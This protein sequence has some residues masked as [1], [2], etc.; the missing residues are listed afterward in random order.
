MN[1]LANDGLH[2]LAIN[3]LEELGHTVFT[4]HVEQKD[5]AVWINENDVEAL[6]VRSATKVRE[7]LI[8]NCPN[9]KWI[10]RAGVGLDNIDVDYAT[11]Q[12]RHVFNTPKASSRSVAELVM[13][14]IYDW[15][16]RVGPANYMMGNA[17][18][19]DVKK[20]IS[21]ISYEVQG[22]TLGVIGFG[23]IGQTVATLAEANGMEILVY[24]PNVD[25]KWST[26]METLL[27]ESDFITVHISGKAE[28]LK[29][30]D[31]EMTKPNAVVINTARGGCINEE[32]L[33]NAIK[34]RRIA[35][36][37]LD[38]FMNEPEPD[39]R[40]LNNSRVIATPHIAGSTREAQAKIGLELVD[41][42]IALS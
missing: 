20:G 2:E 17:A 36:A 21:R 30:V 33:L 4:Q 14:Y 31:F 9:L 32:D 27:I 5:L 8:K 15:S 1:I 40:L 19:N 23:N 35:G 11:E 16:R 39:R 18:F 10:G 42:L 3:K 22:K 28:V 38:V 26:S 37:C 29:A 6:F 24:D 12:G 41:Q 7:D 13:T 25:S 34:E